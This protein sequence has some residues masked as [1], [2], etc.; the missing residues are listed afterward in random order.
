MG[1]G[2][3]R[4][5]VPYAP[6]VLLPPAVGRRPGR[7]YVPDA[8]LLRRLAR[9]RD[10]AAFEILARR[11]AGAVWTACR[12]VLRS[13]ADAEDAFQAAFLVLARKAGAIRGAS[14]GAWL[15]RVAVRVS[16]RLRARSSRTESVGP[17][18]LDTLP[19][20]SVTALDSD[21]AAIVHQEIARLPE[22]YQL[23]IVLCELEGQTYAEAAKVL[24]WSVGTVSGRL[25]RARAVLRDRL[26]RR[27]LAP[28]AGLALVLPAETLPSTATAAAMAAM[29]GPV[30][31]PIST[32]AE[33]ALSAMRT[34]KL[35]LTAAVIASVGLLGLVGVGTGLA[36]PRAGQPVAIFAEPKLPLATAAPIP[37]ERSI[38]GNWF[39][40]KGGGP[41]PTAFPELKRPDVRPKLS[42]EDDFEKEFTR[43][44][45]RLFGEGTLKI[46]PS[47]DTYHRLLKARLHQNI[48]EAYRFWV[49]VQI[50]QYS[51]TEFLYILHFM[52]DMREATVEL[53]MTDPK[54]LIPRLE[55]LVV[56][57][58]EWERFTDA[59]VAAG[60][61]PP[62]QLHKARAHRLGAEATLWKAKNG[63]PGG[64]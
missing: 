1:A 52:V 10:P 61:D 48:W 54:N 25:S 40:E 19:V 6:S 30:P 12:R 37:S 63:K 11:H 35:K 31:L 2:I 8:E 32:L 44:C 4:P 58:K 18:Q 49:R 9:D 59:R 33:G 47:D 29:T 13:D 60:T 22:R 56:L 23:P 24:G 20:S 45:P 62:H 15:H 57:A 3:P 46:E 21:A 64:R 43:I 7:D 50:G 53:W 26:T 28:A 27:G 16:L 39:G 17:D 41:I 51:S 42:S 5:G 38:E 36:W 55:D 34:A 14:V